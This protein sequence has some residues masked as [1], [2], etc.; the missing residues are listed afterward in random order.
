MKKLEAEVKEF[1]VKFLNAI[2]LS[3]ALVEND[4]LANIKG[5]EDEDTEDKSGSKK[6]TRT[7]VSL[8]MKT[9]NQ[10]RTCFVGG[11]WWWGLMK[12]DWMNYVNLDTEVIGNPEPLE[13]LSMRSTI[14]QEK[15]DEPC[16][17]KCT[18]HIS[19]KRRK[20]KGNKNQKLVDGLPLTDATQ[21]SDTSNVTRRKAGPLSKTRSLWSSLIKGESDAQA[22]MELDQFPRPDSLANSVGGDDNF[23][24]DDDTID[25]SD[26][27]DDD[28][29][30]ITL[31][32]GKEQRGINSKSIN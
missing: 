2:K 24:E 28:P 17:C 21:N 23:F 7:K 5:N 11:K 12:N 31:A 32:V 22:K 29:M 6:D 1:Q 27:P 26:L 19:L 25:P 10:V 20:R 9:V 8:P 3:K 15:L 16:T 13:L 4:P 14:K 30:K 18:E